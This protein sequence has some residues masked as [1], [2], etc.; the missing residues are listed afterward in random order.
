M[1]DAMTQDERAQL[2]Q[3]VE[4][5]EQI[6]EVMPADGITLQTLYE[7]FIK[8]EQPGKA[9]KYLAQLTDFAADSESQEFLAFALQQYEALDESSTEVE[10]RKE[11]LRALLLVESAGKLLDVAPGAGPQAAEGTT[12][13]GEQDIKA[14]MALAWDLYQ[15]EQLTQE[16]YSGLLNDLAE[17]SSRT[18]G[19]PVT[20]LHVLHDRRFSRFER[21][22]SHMSTQSGVP[23]ISLGS[24]EKNDNLNE[25]LSLGF[26]TRR[27]VLPF[28]AVGDDLLVAVLNPFDKMRL[29]DAGRASGQHCHPYLVLPGD[30]DQR[31]AEI[32]ESL[33]M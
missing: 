21:L 23:I 8:L 33:N 25:A 15:E 4:T 20:V 31:L 18:L 19:V 30:Y 32:K 16:E 27:G 9:F 28:A 17:M 26:I 11:R 2:E 22:L 7:N 24:Y 10:E 13:S 3:M 1:A 5:L 6:L 14:E 29:L 12:D